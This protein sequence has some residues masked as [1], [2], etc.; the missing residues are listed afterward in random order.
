MSLQDFEERVRKEYPELVDSGIIMFDADSD[1]IFP[2]DRLKIVINTDN[3]LLSRL[4]SSSTHS[5]ALQA[6][7]ELQDMI[8]QSSDVTHASYGGGYYEG[9]AV[10]SVKQG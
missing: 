5:R 8:D 9:G 1:S 6:S 4:T 2:E 7:I 10:V 3:G